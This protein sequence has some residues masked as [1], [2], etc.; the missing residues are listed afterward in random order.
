MTE[1]L[2]EGRL[3]PA[4]DGK[5]LL[6]HIV[7]VI[8]VVAVLSSLTAMVRPSAGAALLV[9]TLVWV[10]FFVPLMRWD[11]TL[12]KRLMKLRVVSA[13]GSELSVVRKAIRAASSA[14]THSP[15]SWSRRFS[16]SIPAPNTCSRPSSSVDGWDTQLCRYTPPR[17]AE[18]TSVAPEQNTVSPLSGSSTSVTPRMVLMIESAM[19]YASPA[20][21]P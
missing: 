14:G 4:S 19:R 2:S 18:S 20:E 3:W 6:A 1:D 8:L 16:P 7:D 9:V 21:S 15:V 10:A 11:A 12:G 17:I 13:D 5:R